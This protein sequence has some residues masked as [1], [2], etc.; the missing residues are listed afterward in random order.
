MVDVHPNRARPADLD[1][2]LAQY[3][4]W[5]SPLIDEFWARGLGQT[6]FVYEKPRVV[7][8]TEGILV[9]TPC[10]SGGMPAPA[11][12]LSY[13]PVD[14][15][16]YI[17]EPFMKDE[18][19]AGEDGQQ[20]DFVVATVMAHEWGHHIQNVHNYLDAVAYETGNRPELAPIITRGAELAS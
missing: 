15:T 17:Y 18:L 11:L 20:R 3:I 6:G 7:I 16:V 5:I 12:S 1:R 10:T 13:C 8:I 9:F 19:V 4:G 2:N 14:R